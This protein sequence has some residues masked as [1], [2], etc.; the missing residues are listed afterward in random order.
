MNMTTSVAL[1]GTL[2]RQLSDALIRS[3]GQEDI[4]LITYD[5]SAGRQRRSG[6]LRAIVE[7]VNGDREIHGNATIN[8]AYVLRA[9]ATAAREG[10]GVAMAH[11]HPLGRGWQP[12]SGPDIDAEASYAN[13]VRELTGLPLIGLT[14]AGHDRA[15][16]ARHWDQGNADTVMATHSINV[17]VIDE[18][19]IVTFNDRL[20]PIPPSNGSLRRTVSAWGQELQ[21]NLVRRRILVVGLGSV[22][23]DVATRLAASGFTDLGFMDFDRVE[24]VNLDRL[25]GATRSDAK[26]GRLKVEVAE[27]L[28]RAQATAD[29]ISIESLPLSICNPD[30]LAAALDYDL[31]FSCVDRPWPRAVLNAVAYTDYIPVIDGGVGID[32]FDDGGMRNAIWRSH[33]IGPGRPCM[34]CIG[35]LDPAEVPLD[36][37]GLLDD[38]AYITQTGVRPVGGSANVA[39]L[40]ASVSGALLTQFVS[41]N[42][43]PGGIGDPGPT[44]YIL[45]THT[46]EHL[47]CERSRHCVTEGAAGAGD[48]RLD[49]TGPHRPLGIQSARPSTRVRK[50]INQVAA[51]VSRMV[52][53]T[54]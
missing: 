39:M 52:H 17:R 23:L 24:G 3:D 37:E 26:Q 47:K 13:L 20:R 6:L 30:G 12:M 28:A 21:N 54:D 8:S 1:T 49:L 51:A 50:V 40:S 19:F 29:H 10:L 41:F 43:A 33:V 32:A 45:S 27:R 35:Q 16:S 31:I 4:R 18:S 11:S 9:A 36:I 53:R 14:I 38:P 46:L 44:R 15:W 7:P 5:P 2:H 34:T 42:V 22:G 48:A 25:I